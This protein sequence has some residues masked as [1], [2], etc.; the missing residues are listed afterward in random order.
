MIAGTF[1]SAGSIIEV[2]RHIGV[3]LL[4]LHKAEEFKAEEPKVNKTPNFERMT[5]LNLESYGNEIGLKL[6][7]TKTK[8]N[9]IKELEDFISTQEEF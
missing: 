8:T 7:I 1:T 9:L 2:E 6:D 3:M 5:K 4:N